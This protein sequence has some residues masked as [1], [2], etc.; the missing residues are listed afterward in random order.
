M[1]TVRLR[2]LFD[3]RHL[4][5][6][7]RKSE[8]LK[9][10]WLL[11]KPE[12]ETISDLASQLIFTFDLEDS[13]PNGLILSM[14][15][16]VLPP[17]EST[18]ILK[19]RDIIR[20]KKKGGALT[21]IIRVGDQA[22]SAEDSD[23]EEKRPV[24][25]GVKLLA[26]KEFEE[27]TGGYQSE[28]EE[29]KYDHPEDQL[30]VENTS[31]EKTISKKRKSS[32][33]LQS[34]QRR[35]KTRT[36]SPVK[37]PVIPES[38]ENDVHTEQKESSRRKGV[39]KHKSS[40]IKGKSDII[41]TP[42]VDEGVN[43]IGEPMRSEKWCQQFQENGAGSV[44]VSNVP[45]GMRK[46]PSRS[47]RR[48]KAKRQWLREFAKSQKK[49]SHAP[50]KDTQQICPEHQQPDQNTDIEDEIVPIVVRP[51]HI[52]FE[53]LD[54]DQVVQ[55]NQV[56][57]EAFQWSGTTSKKKGQKWGKEKPSSCK[58]NGYK[59]WNQDSTEKLTIEEG[60][61]VTDHI[62]FDKLVPLSSLPKRSDLGTIKE[63]NTVLIILQEGD[64]VA[65]RLVELSSLWCPELSSFRVGR[66]SW[67]DPGSS[68]VILTPV[69]EH[70]IVS[71]EKTDEESSELQP[72]TSVYREDGSLEIDFASLVD[73]RI[74]K[75]GNTV[76]ATAVIGKGDEAP[77]SNQVAVSGVRPNNNN[78][79]INAP[80]RENGEVNM[81]EEISQALSEKK[82]QLLQKDGWPKKE[83]LG[84]NPWSYK[85]LRSNGLGPTMALLR[86][87]TDP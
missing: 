47:A 49:E 70:P 65:Y 39:R 21:D 63:I 20:V 28:P 8:G 78:K 69:A 55:Q 46:L 3:D 44:H 67:Y 26:I 87:Q 36:T 56:P 71:D 58:I 77:V 2:L 4:L 5:S 72:N 34:S 40:N 31:N 81:W 52:R 53:P 10:S 62:D 25:D 59:D 42:E 29:D 84:R 83:S 17:F 51:G 45:D 6:K 16:F 30:V 66:I 27:E 18:R 23:I 43:N 85:T 64:V 15:G 11:L 57:V 13:C 37:C 61:L 1:E 24:L 33:K 22:K 82:S 50:E 76:P 41:S 86:T 19:D 80:I 79:E 38:V 12:H 14:D 54:E 68:R 75:H 32:N 60:E 48:K 35:K 73:V 9:R 74:I 7:S